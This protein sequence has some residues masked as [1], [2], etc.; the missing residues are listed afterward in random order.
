VLDAVLFD[1]DG[2]IRQWDEPELW[3]FEAEAGFEAGTVHAV[4]FDTEVN[5]PVIR[6]QVSIGLL[7]NTHDRFEEYLG[8]V[9]LSGHFDVI[10][11]THRLGVAKPESG[12]YLKALERL[13]VSPERCLFTDD[14]VHN[15]HGAHA[16]GNARPPLRTRR[17][18]HRTA[19]GI[20]TACL[21]SHR[22][23]R[24]CRCDS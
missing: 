13:D 6:G 10:A 11:N 19:C 21:R 17:R 15:V 18:L 5:H 4:A 22:R 23:P 2:V 14:L 12:A 9:G 8:R 24:R 1:F 20:W 7:T 16:V 3:T